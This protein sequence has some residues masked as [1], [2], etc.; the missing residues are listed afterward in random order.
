MKGDTD[1]IVELK[2]FVIGNYHSLVGY[3]RLYLYGRNS[4]LLAQRRRGAIFHDK[5]S[6]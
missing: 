6:T 2:L 4:S 5:G 3:K 1:K